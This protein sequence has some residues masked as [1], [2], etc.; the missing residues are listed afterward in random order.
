MQTY[1]EIHETIINNI[2]NKINKSKKNVHWNGKYKN[3]Q[4]NVNVNMNNNGKRKKQKLIIHDKEVFQNNN[5]L[6]IFTKPTNNMSL[7]KRLSND[8]LTNVLPPNNT[9]N[10]R[11]NKKHKVGKKTRKYRN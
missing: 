11:R 1:G 6:D 10:N 9:P 3:N 7:E 2:G 4:W 8:F 5:M